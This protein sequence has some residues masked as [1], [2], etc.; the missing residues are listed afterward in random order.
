MH[1]FQFPFLGLL[2]E[3]SAPLPLQPRRRES[4][5]GM[6]LP[7]QES[8]L[9]HQA[10]VAIGF[11]VVLKQALVHV[12]GGGKHHT[13]DVDVGVRRVEGRLRDAGEDVGLAY[14]RSVFQPIIHAELCGVAFLHRGDVEHVVDFPERKRVCV[15]E[16]DFLKL[17]LVPHVEFGEE[18]FPSGLYARDVGV[19][20]ERLQFSDYGAGAREQ[21]A[22]LLCDEVGHENDEGV[23]GR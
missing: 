16:E 11:D 13:P 7:V 21:V 4:A 5:L 23:L 1:D 6:E 17:G 10:V 8:L 22:L 15:E 20:F 2:R 18:I 3:E 14:R 9:G 12:L 19:P